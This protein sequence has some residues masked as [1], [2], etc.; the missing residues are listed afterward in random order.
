MRNHPP[1]YSDPF[2]VQWEIPHPRD[3]IERKYVV[4]NGIAEYLSMHKNNRYT[5]CHEVFISSTYNPL[6]DII[7]HPAFDLDLKL[8]KESNIP[9]SLSELQRYV[10][11]SDD[12][13][14]M[15]QEDIIRILC[16]QYPAFKER[17]SQLSD[18]W[19][20]M[21]SPSLEKVSKHLVI[22]N[23]CFSMWRAQMNILID[24][25]LTLDRPYVKAIDNAIIRK[26]GSL[27]LPLNHKKHIIENDKIVKYSPTLIFDDPSHKFTDGLVCIHNDNMYTMEESIFLSP[28]D[29]HTDYQ[30][31][32]KITDE[33][34]SFDNDDD[35][36]DLSSDDDLLHAFITMDKRYKTGLTPG[37]ISGR[38][39]SLIRKREGQCPISGRSHT[40]DN[41]YIFSKNGKIFFGC[42]RGCSVTLNGYQKKCIDISLWKGKSSDDMARLI[43]EDINNMN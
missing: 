39:L 2:I 24:E 30:S 16:K 36:Y 37:K 19:I 7:A 41:A 25:L 27:R 28:S 11:L 10:G 4:F 14:Q 21:T 35:E 5:S 29:L 20:W 6:D 8:P 17:I 9:T 3:N 23:I 32:V 12:W 34:H 33:Y 31:S 26:A 40:S 18:G 42:H 43:F 13:K 38:Y 15:F 1:Q 22:R